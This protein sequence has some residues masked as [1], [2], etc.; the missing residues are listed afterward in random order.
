MTLEEEKLAIEE[1]SKMSLKNNSISTL[2]SER[3]L[4]GDFVKEE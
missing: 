2:Q 1:F 3:F 4:E